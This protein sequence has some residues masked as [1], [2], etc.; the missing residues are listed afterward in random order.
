MTAAK[1][2]MQA[3]KASDEY[4]TPVKARSDLELIHLLMQAD[5]CYAPTPLS[6]DRSHEHRMT[7]WGFHTPR[8]VV[9][10]SCRECCWC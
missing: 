5:R 8:P 9:G 2:A 7:Y 4:V 6:L 3:Y 10:R 1:Q